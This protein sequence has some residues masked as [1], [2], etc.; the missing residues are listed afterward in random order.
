[1]MK[2]GVYYVGD[3]CYV[4]HE[5]WD[6]VCEEV[7]KDNECLEGEFKLPDGRKFAMYNTY[8]G[9]GEYR[10]REGLTYDVDAGSIGCILLSDIDLQADGNFLTGG[11]IVTFD[12]DFYT[13]NDEGTLK[14]GEVTINTRNGNDDDYC[15]EEEDEIYDFD[16][17]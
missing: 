15:Y 1:M 6:E 11:Q 3:L 2:A 17:K 13:A 14:F 7:I 16:D 4:L 8:W 5:V 9:D 12:R 10:D